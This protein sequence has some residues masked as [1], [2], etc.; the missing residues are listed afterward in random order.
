MVFP[1]RA[2]GVIGIHDC[3]FTLHMNILR[4]IKEVIADGIDRLIVVRMKI[5]VAIVGIVR[6]LLGRGIIMKIPQ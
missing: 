4:Q 2:A 5:A 6:R 1:S 3:S